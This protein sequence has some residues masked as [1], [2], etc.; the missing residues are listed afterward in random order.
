MCNR[1]KCLLEDAERLLLCADRTLAQLEQEQ[2][3]GQ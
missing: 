1:W 2:H 3:L